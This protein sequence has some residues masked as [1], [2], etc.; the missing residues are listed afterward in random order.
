VTEP[1]VRHHHRFADYLALEE[2]SNVRHEYFRG[3]I[4]AMA[5]GTPDHAA[6]A[7]NLGAALLER[8][9][10]RPCRVFSSDLRVR[11]LATGL[12]TYPD[13]TVICGPLERDPES[14]S[15]VV[16]PLLVAEVLSDATEEYDRGDK[17][18][19]YRR[20]P[21]LKECVL[22]SHRRAQVEVWR[23]NESG[24]W[25][26]EETTAGGTIRLASLGCEIAVDDIYRGGLQ[27][28]AG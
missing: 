1:A 19:H 6:L 9:R 18:E 17:L 15:T 16:N 7:M 27:D 22:V 10:D 24:G 12:A 21:S 20:I 28:I 13:V 5:G 14:R 23:R 11:V 4:Y 26:H 2:S 25:S 3:E 8:V